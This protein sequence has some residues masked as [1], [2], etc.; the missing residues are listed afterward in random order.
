[1]EKIRTCNICGVT[2][3]VAEFYRGVTSRCKEC[4]KEK[5]RQNR[6]DNVDY[7]RAYDAKRFRE[8]PRVVERHRR[9]QR[10]E[11]GKASMRKS[12]EKWVKENQDKRAAHVI[13]GNAV[14]DGRVGKPE[15]CEECGAMGKIHGHHDDYTKPL[16]VEWLCQTCHFARHKE[17]GQCHPAS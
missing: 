1:M 11:A 10:T 12:R 9:Y 14:R 15:V 2:S 7:Y 17:D 4:H 3:E 5:V 16:D 6:A 8:D 13:L